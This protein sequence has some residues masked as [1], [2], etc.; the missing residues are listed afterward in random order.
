VTADSAFSVWSRTVLARARLTSSIELYHRSG[1]L[2]SR[3]ALNLP[4]YTGA[5]QKPAPSLQCE[6]EVFGEG[7]PFGTEERN[8]L[9]A[10]RNICVSGPGGEPEIAGS[11]VVH[12][13][14]DYR[15]LPFIAS[16]S[17]YF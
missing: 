12:V 3:F 17:P 15:T 9:H 7:A 1:E 16:Q 10:E 13:A 8:L 4:E 14:F 6:W 2:V 11:I 5:A